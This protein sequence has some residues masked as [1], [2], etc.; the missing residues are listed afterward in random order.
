MRSRVIAD[1]TPPPDRLRDI[2]TPEGVPLRFAVASAGDRILAFLLDCAILI[3]CV[4]AITILALLA[5]S[6][7]AM[8]IGILFSFLARNFYFMWF[9]QRWRGA[10]PG[11]RALGIR[12]IDAHGLQL[13]VE[14]IIVRN[15][16][17]DLEIFL[18]LFF[19]ANPESAFWGFPRW[20]AWGAGLW[21]IF[22]PLIPLFNRDRRRVGDLVGGTMV[23]RSPRVALLDDLVEK[24]VEAKDTADAVYAFSGEQLATYGIY[25]LQILE[26]ILR[27]GGRSEEPELFD[28]VSAK[29]RAKIGWE[30]PKDDSEAFLRAFYSQL[31]A[32][33]ERRMLFGKRRK[34]KHSKEE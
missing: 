7:S 18:P 29:I 6:N 21:L 15:L 8:V 1:A 9:E 24:E 28:R 14:A 20:T 13:R 12:V 31:R 33:L 17:R 4:G 3:V 2:V 22:I 11:K 30:G 25:E 26:D 27:K 19:L 5:H 23:I 10:T 16:F 32:H 34:D